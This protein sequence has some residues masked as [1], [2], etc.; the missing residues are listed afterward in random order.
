MR[1]IPLAKSGLRQGGFA[2]MQS[3][4]TSK[5]L[6][7]P[8]DRSSGLPFEEPLF[9]AV[10]F[11][12]T[13]LDEFTKT[14]RSRH[15]R[16]PQRQRILQVLKATISRLHTN[17]KAFNTA[18]SGCNARTEGRICWDLFM[19]MD[20]PTDQPVVASNSE[21]GSHLPY[22][23]LKRDEAVRFIRTQ[24]NRWLY[25]ICG[26]LSTCWPVATNG[27]PASTVLE[28]YTA[29]AMLSALFDI[30]ELTVNSGPVH[31]HD[32]ISKETYYRTSKDRDEPPTDT[33]LARDSDQ[34]TGG[35]IRRGLSLSQSLRDT[36]LFWLPVDMFTWD[37]LR[38]K[39]Q[40]LLQTAYATTY[41]HQQLQASPRTRL[42]TSFR[43][44]VE[45][46]LQRVVQASETGKAEKDSAWLIAQQTLTQLCLFRYTN[47]LLS[48]LKETDKRHHQV[49]LPYILSQHIDLEE[50]TGCYG[51]SY[52]LIHRC[53]GG[54][55][56]VGL[57]RAGGGNAS[58][59]GGFS[60]FP[61]T[62]STRIQL[63]FDWDDGFH[64]S[65]W[66]DAVWRQWARY[67]FTQVTTILSKEEGIAWHSRIGETA[68]PHLTILPLYEK[69]KMYQAVKRPRNIS[70]ELSA[71]RA[72]KGY[73]LRWIA[74]QPLN[75]ET[76]DRPEDACWTLLRQDKGAASINSLP[77]I[78]EEN[79][80]I[81][82]GV[83]FT[84]IEEVLTAAAEAVDEEG[85]DDDSEGEEG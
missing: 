41:L 49:R 3:Y 76:V 70:K 57:C 19:T 55:P 53:T 48:R 46:C 33:S 28:Q 69:D 80:T 72:E 10:V 12:Q 34:P 50:R 43:N 44:V 66:D 20:P 63:L 79:P 54:P 67:C 68:T 71:A 59:T 77:G 23:V 24:A 65:N 30:L 56:A 18:K 61:N 5:D 6:F 14:Y 27:R 26:V 85:K 81:L 38:F 1:V 51:L 4:V 36:N 62:W 40:V 52:D 7:A 42:E 64:R 47:W 45:R 13:V 78:L 82:S 15:S 17:L 84:L 2:F 74:C 9:R 22:L 73:V 35:D 16:P 60:R 83:R 21:D 58:A 75:W 32:R 39:P 29:S 31:R 8:V 37:Q 11:T 25:A